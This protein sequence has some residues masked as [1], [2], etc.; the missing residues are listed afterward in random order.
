MVGCTTA[1]DAHA[2]YVSY[3]NS[4]AVSPWGDVIAR[5][6]AE[7]T[8]LYVELDLALVDKIRGELPLLS[9]RRTDVYRLERS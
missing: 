1:R 9:A 3:S 4:I 8:V 2:P 7:A 5:A 6:G